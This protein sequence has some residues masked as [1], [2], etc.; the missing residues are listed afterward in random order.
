MLH[1]LMKH[2]MR[3]KI[4]RNLLTPCTLPSPLVG[5]FS[6]TDL[7]NKGRLLSAA[8]HVNRLSFE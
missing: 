4:K 6:D 8:P 2:G 1:D 3:N 5:G 7:Y